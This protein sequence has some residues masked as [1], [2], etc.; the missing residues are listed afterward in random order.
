MSKNKNYVQ[1]IVDVTYT[2]KV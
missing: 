1:N 2:Q